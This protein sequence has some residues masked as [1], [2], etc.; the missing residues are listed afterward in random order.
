NPRL[1][2]FNGPITV[3]GT[4]GYLF[5]SGDTDGGLFSPADGVVTIKTNATER[6]R[7]DASGNVGIGTTPTRAKLE[8]S[9]SIGSTS[10]TF[11]ANTSGVSIY[12]NWP[13]IGFNSYYGADNITR[14][15]VTGYTGAIW[16]DP[17]S[18]KMMFYNGSSAAAGGVSSGSAQMT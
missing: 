14:P 17:G 1:N 3:N 6:V 7:V 9:G 10:A 4:S 16:F 12:S 18:G 8:L 13:G 11:G 5:N 2:V 15:L